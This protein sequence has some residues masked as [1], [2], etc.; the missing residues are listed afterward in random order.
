MRRIDVFSAVTVGLHGTAAQP[1]HVAADGRLVFKSLEGGL[2]QVCRFGRRYLFRQDSS[3]SA[4][5]LTG[6]DLAAGVLLSCANC[7]S[8]ISALHSG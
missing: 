7:Q 5:I 3:Y 6:T 1:A 4:T 8:G 2:R